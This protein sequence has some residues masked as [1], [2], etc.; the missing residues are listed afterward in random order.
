MGRLRYEE[1]K[2]IVESAG[3]SLI[4]ETYQN[5]DQELELRCPENHRVFTSLKKFRGTPYCP[6]C[7]SNSF[8]N[9]DDK[10]NAKKKGIKRILGLDQSTQISGWSIYDDDQLVKYGIFYTSLE[11]QELRDHAFKEWLINMIH[12]WKPD[13][14]AIEDI[15][16]QEF[17]QGKKVDSDN[18]KGILIFK[19]LARL[20][21]VIIECC[22]EQGI[23]YIVCPTNTWRAYCKV[24]GSTRTDKKRSMQ[25]I[26]K[27][28]YDVTVSE[29]EADAIGIGYY[30]SKN[31]SKQ[32]TIINWEE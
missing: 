26:V 30:A 4:T 19:T 21:G 10:I 1:V 17:R 6:N 31:Y 13:L 23:D 28:K 7:N 12:N 8:K 29:D 20:Q 11:K 22:I 24:K 27:D 18:V 32:N 5:L 3:W 9:F 14:I 16:L 15:Q 2:N 25:L